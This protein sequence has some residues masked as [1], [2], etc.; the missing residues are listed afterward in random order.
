LKI[1]CSEHKKWCCT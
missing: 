1:E